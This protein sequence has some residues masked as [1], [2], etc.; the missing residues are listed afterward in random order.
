VT[1]MVKTRL[2]TPQERSSLF[3][4]QVQKAPMN[5]QGSPPKQNPSRK[6][7]MGAPPGEEV[8]ARMVVVVVKYWGW[9][10]TTVGCG[11]TATTFP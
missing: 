5:Q 11:V 8:G 3:A 6:K 7:I 10:Y 2:T 1:R 4:E 9:A